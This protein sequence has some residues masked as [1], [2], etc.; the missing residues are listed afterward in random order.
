[1]A[2]R[3][4]CL[5]PS[6]A[7]REQSMRP[8]RSATTVDGVDGAATWVARGANGD[9]G[10]GFEEVDVAPDGTIY[11]T[12]VN[13]LVRRVAFDGVTTVADAEA[14]FTTGSDAGESSLA[15]R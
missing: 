14:G 1:M 6:S 7:P 15:W 12:D 13:G 3:A 10:R 4:R 9:S 11:I 5:S 2:T 8:T